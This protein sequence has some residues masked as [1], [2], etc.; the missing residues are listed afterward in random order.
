[1][2]YNIRTSSK[3]TSIDCMYDILPDGSPVNLE[4]S[5]EADAFL[6]NVSSSNIL[7]KISA[8]RNQNECVL[9]QVK[10]KSN[11]DYQQGRESLPT[12]SKQM[13]YLNTVACRAASRD[14]ANAIPSSEA[15]LWLDHFILILERKNNDLSWKTNGI[16]EDQDA[17]MFDITNSFCKKINFVKAALRKR[18]FHSLTSF[19]DLLPEH[20][21]PNYALAQSIASS[22]YN[23]H[24]TLSLYSDWDNEK[25]WRKFEESG[26]LEHYLRFTAMSSL[27]S[28]KG[29]AD[30]CSPFLLDTL[31]R[32]SYLLKTRFKAGSP[33]G[34][35]VRAIVEQQE[36]P[37]DGGCINLSK[38][39]RVLEY[40]RTMI[41]IS[42]AAQ[43]VVK[44]GVRQ[45][46]GRLCR[47][48]NK[49]E[50]DGLGGFTPF[51]VCS[52]CHQTCY[53]SKRCQ[54]QDWKNH[55]S[56]CKKLVKTGR[57]R[58]HSDDATSIK[59]VMQ[60]IRKNFIVII[61]GFLRTCKETGL[62]LS[63]LLLEIDLMPG[64]DGTA[65]PALRDSP[66]FKIGPTANYHEGKRPDEP[67]WFHKG[68]SH[69]KKNIH[70][71]TK[72]IK[73]HHDK[74]S[75]GQIL[76]MSRLPSGVV[77]VDRVLLNADKGVVLF[78]KETVE[79]FR[80]AIEEGDFVPLS[81]TF[82]EKGCAYIKKQ[83]FSLKKQEGHDSAT[84][85]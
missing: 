63:D 53:C 83:L 78:A 21:L 30:F 12:F 66:A 64:I 81:K 48:C 70:N 34:D 68:T 50:H 25:I 13:E 20:K 32:C 42:D 10:Q 80:S 3:Q 60:I 2:A 79:A 72:A 51:M 52:L 67:D 11:M 40:M 15:E 77:S 73:F 29:N 31:I 57:Q 33:C 27:V 5:R 69:Y 16:L 43:T 36:G 23:T 22:L 6:T 55:R 7:K 17:M 65:P 62:G 76:C 37:S 84:L 45:K 59:S 82:G 4:T 71:I 58:Q 18:L 1:M 35:A 24:Q 46:V 61:A 49:S 19:I 39:E 54:R 74:L 85:H 26:F 8:V 56:E 9:N 44:G 38:N 75:S 47:K 41:K 14:C 28:R